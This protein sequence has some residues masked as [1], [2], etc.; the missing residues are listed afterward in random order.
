MFMKL[1][2]TTLNYA[3]LSVLST[4]LYAHSEVQQSKAIETP[5]IPLI[6]IQLIAEENNEI[7]KTIYTTEDLT[8]TPNSQKTI[9]EFLKINPNIQFSNNANAAQNQGE[10]TALDLSIHGALPYNNS[11]LING[12][13]INNDINPY[14]NNTSSNS[15][16]ELAGS[17]QAVTINT[18]LLCSLEVLDSNVSAQ[19]GQFTGG[20]ISAKTC[21]PKTAV[22]KIHGTLSYDY[23]HS[24]WNRF[25]Y[26]DLAEEETFTDPTQKEA[27]KNY[28]KQGFSILNYGR[29]TENFGINL[30]FTQR[31]STIDGVSTLLDA[32]P[33]NETRQADNAII[34]LFYD[35]SDDLSIKFAYQYFEDKKLA[36]LSNVLTDG[37]QQNSDSHSFNLNIDKKF[38]TFSLKQNLSYQE[39]QN[40][41][42]STSTEQ[43]SWNYSDAKNWVSSNASTEGTSGTIY[44]QQ[45]NIDYNINA[46]FNPIAWGNTTHRFNFGAGFAHVEANWS[47]PEDFTQYFKANKFGTDC[48]RSDGSIADACDASYVPSKNS[49]GQYSTTKVIFSAGNIDTQQDTWYAFAEDR[50]RWKE[51]FEAVL[52]LRTD[53]DSIS[54]KTNL[55]PRTA[56]NYMPFSN[57]NFI[58]TAGWNRYYDRYLYSF[59]LQ[60]GI[61]DLKT[62]Y[63]RNNIDSAWGN[64][65]KS[66]SINV[67]RSDLSLPYA[68]EWLVGISGELNNWAYQLK[69]IHRDYKDQY[70][71]VRPDP[72]DLWTRIYTNSKQYQSKNITLNFNNMRPIEILAAQHR[73]NIAVNYTNTQRDYNNADETELKEFNAV[74]Y[75]GNITDPSDIPASDFNTPLSA[76]LSWDFT[77][78]DLPGLNIS[79]FLIYKPDYDGIGKSTIA[80][81]DQISHQGLPIIY[82]YNDIRV[83]SVF[84]WDMRITYTQPLVKNVIGIFGLTVNNVTNRHNVYLDSDFYF[85]SEIGRQFIADMSFKF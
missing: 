27:Q 32:R 80:A 25:N 59:D 58:L 3:I 22:G 72:S 56:L 20:V 47:R 1:L 24:S 9:S 49:N 30:G 75:N 65:K 85:K 4:S 26:I 36:F 52:G 70:Y 2:P 54:K 61:G 5:V 76:R 46:I 34:E 35:P 17:S 16:N 28:H 12:M 13:S 66:S 19:Y 11:F 62:T 71:L 55:A 82:A 38:N 79:N 45:K 42:Q 67:K 60:D 8:K 48:I 21:A 31:K 53:Y 7:G 84:R 15:I 18:D 39:K 23:T 41:R 43:Y 50:I 77:P 64:A 14:A 40:Q 81:K 69:Y 73:F 51:T 74:L 44:T 29:L 57:R 33:Y 63:T 78:N 68:D 83:P 6:P 37:I 10:I